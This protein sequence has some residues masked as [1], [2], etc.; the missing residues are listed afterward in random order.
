MPELRHT[1][2]SRPLAADADPDGTQAE[3]NYRLWSSGRYLSS[4]NHAQLLPAESVILARYREA[5]SA[6]VL[7][8]GCGAG[9]ML[10]YLL[11]L[12]SDVHGVDLS[13]RM[14]EHCLSRFPQADVRVG[15]LADLAA[16]VTGP[17]DAVLMPDN[18]IDVFND[19][20]R[21]AVLGDLRG[22]LAPDGLL[23]FSS[24]NLDAWDRP[25]AGGISGKLAAVDGIV[26][27]AAHRN[28]VW[29]VQTAIGMPARRR[30]RK[31]LGPLQYREGD[32]AI[33]NDSAHYHGLLH[34]YIGRVAQERQLSGAGFRLLDVLEAD[35]RTVPA[36]Q[37]GQSGSL[38]YVAT[39]DS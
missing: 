19:V 7:D 24:H 18:L 12:G 23:I 36:A 16:T 25:R 29:W 34:Y 26:R 15:D 4:Y 2:G 14:V 21:R 37:E 20:Q 13:S 10:G 17:F 28:A 9:R 6:R 3:V 35:G 31:R 11:M 27:T 33:V 8:V 30:N 39:A 1:T 22:L 32:Y 38:Y 5:I